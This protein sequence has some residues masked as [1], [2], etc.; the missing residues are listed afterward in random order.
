[1]F[2]NILRKT[3][4]LFAQ[5]SCHR[6]V[7]PIKTMAG[8]GNKYKMFKENNESIWYKLVFKKVFGYFY[9]NTEDKGQRRIN[10]AVKEILKHT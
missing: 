10:C 9:W 8:G 7:I 4:C 1:M 2:W 6:L 3:P 5:A